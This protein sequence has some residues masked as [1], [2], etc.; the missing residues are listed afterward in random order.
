MPTNNLEIDAA[1]A[2]TALG[3]MNF[4]GQDLPALGNNWQVETQ[5]TAAYTGGWQHVGL[6]GVAGGQQLLPLHDDPQPQPAA[7]ST[8][9]S[10]RTP[11]RDAEGTRARAAATQHPGDQTGP[12]TIRM[13]YTRAAGANTVRRSTR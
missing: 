10:P 7:T 13:R 2:A 11:E 5:F 4:I 8:S 12:V 9:S 3:P 1:A 6:I